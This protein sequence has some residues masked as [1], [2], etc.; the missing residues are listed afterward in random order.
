VAVRRAWSVGRNL[1][2]A[3]GGSALRFE[4]WT[5]LDIKDLEIRHPGTVAAYA[6]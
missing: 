5:R 6:E 4:L 3:G 2:K 1:R